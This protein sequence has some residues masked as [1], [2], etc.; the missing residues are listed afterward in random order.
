MYLEETTNKYT[1]YHIL[2]EK[3][4]F[5]C[6]TD[7]YRHTCFHLYSLQSSDIVKVSWKKESFMFCFSANYFLVKLIIY[8]SISLRTKRSEITLGTPEQEASSIIVNDRKC[9]SELSFN[10]QED[11]AV[12]E[13]WCFKSTNQTSNS[14][15]CQINHVTLSRPE[16]SNAKCTAHRLSRPQQLGSTES[17]ESTHAGTGNRAHNLL[18]RPKT[19]TPLSL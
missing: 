14:V 6:H 2:Q 3:M 18:P 5:R 9:I 15:S 13:N 7:F 12:S 1:I 11:H 8:R 10:S 4:K 17:E 19:Y 16:L